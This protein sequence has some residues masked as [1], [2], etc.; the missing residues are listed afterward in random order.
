MNIGIDI[1]DVLADFQKPWLAF[2]NKKY[3]T[4]FT[5]KDIYTYCYMTIF[6]IPLEE[7]HQRVYA[8]YRSKDFEY[9][10]PAKGSQKVINSLSKHHQLYV[11]TSRPNWMS[12]KT[13]TWVDTYFN[14]FITKIIHS[15]QFSL[16]ETEKIP[17]SKL[18]LDNNIT[19]M[20]EDAPGYAQEVAAKGIQVLLLD[21]PWNRELQTT[22]TKIERVVSWNS[23]EQ[24]VRRFC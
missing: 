7:V 24:A 18:C 5:P 11:I 16:D 20:I 22:N 1:D 15:N 21:K 10:L 14:G 8:F 4:H 19:L 9:I 6:G 12:A 13:E 3:R 23:I 17:K 2:Y